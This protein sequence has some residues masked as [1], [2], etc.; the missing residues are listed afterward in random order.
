[1]GFFA[2]QKLFEVHEKGEEKV[3]TNSE[4][5]DPYL[6]ILDKVSLLLL[7]ILNFHSLI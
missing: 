1:M 2:E 3:S 6:V 5:A 4:L 7:A